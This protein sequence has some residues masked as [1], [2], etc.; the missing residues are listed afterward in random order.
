MKIHRL[1]K[2]NSIYFWWFAFTAFLGFV[3][4]LICR[5]GFFTAEQCAFG[6]I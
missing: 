2:E 4:G 1:F 5:F 6:A 3:G